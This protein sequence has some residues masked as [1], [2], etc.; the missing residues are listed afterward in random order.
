MTNGALVGNTYEPGLYTSQISIT[1]SGN[2]TFA[3][4]IYYLEG[5]ISIGG[6][7]TVTAD[8]V[9]LYITGGAFDDGGTGKITFTPLSSPPSPASG[10]V[11]WQTDSDATQVNL[12][13][14]GSGSVI[15]GTIYAPNAAVDIAGGGSGTG[16]QVGA[17]LANS[18][19]CSG[20]GGGK[21]VF[22]ITGQQ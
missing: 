20:G 17:L 22:T 12:H 6:S 11:I 5:G 4:G 15:G 14:S 1:G 3:S 10:M 8:N 19:T 2:Y 18:V 16:L 9:L 7:A 21:P 13:G